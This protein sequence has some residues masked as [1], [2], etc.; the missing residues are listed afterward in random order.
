MSVIFIKKTNFRVT[1]VTRKVVI[2][3]SFQPRTSLKAARETARETAPDT[4]DLICTP[5]SNTTPYVL[6]CIS[7]T[8]SVYIDRVI[9]SPVSI[10]FSRRY[11]D[12]ETLYLQVLSPKEIT[13][14]TKT[15]KI[16]DEMADSILSEV[17]ETPYCLLFRSDLKL[18]IDG[19]LVPESWL[20]DI[21]S[22]ILNSF[23][24]K[25]RKLDYRFNASKDLLI[26]LNTLD[27]LTEY[28]N[29]QRE[30]MFYIK[31]YFRRGTL[32]R[33]PHDFDSKWLM[34]KLNNTECYI[35]QWYDKRIFNKD[36]G[37]NMT[38]F[39]LNRLKKDYFFVETLKIQSPYF[40]TEIVDNGTKVYISNLRELWSFLGHLRHVWKRE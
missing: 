9:N 38:I 17:S 27:F 11:A 13:L 36:S 25:G 2:D 3:K 37:E 20:R 1:S 34:K 30:F 21:L 22:F 12:S 8:L 31:R 35:A 33:V 32:F 18:E 28:D 19:I 15:S 7:S 26:R 10:I 14:N 40:R 4:I 23:L 6:F 5:E 39:L 16:I 29:I 24:S